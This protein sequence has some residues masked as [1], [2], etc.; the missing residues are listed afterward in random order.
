MHFFKSFSVIL[1]QS[2]IWKALW[3]SRGYLF[4]IEGERKWLNRILIQI[5]LITE[6]V[7][8]GQVFKLHWLHSLFCM[9]SS[10]SSFLASS[11]PWISY[12]PSCLRASV[13]SFSLYFF[14]LLLLL[15]ISLFFPFVSTPTNWRQ[16]NWFNSSQSSLIDNF[17]TGHWDY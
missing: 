2:H 14:E 1:I 8:L 15:T 3:D 11:H 13:T 10:S 7:T 5:L 12:S 6:F 9:F 4:V 16:L 17:L